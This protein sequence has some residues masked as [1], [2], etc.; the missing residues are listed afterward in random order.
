MLPCH[1]ASCAHPQDFTSVD[2][3]IDLIADPLAAAMFRIWRCRAV[4]RCKLFIV[5]GHDCF[6]PSSV[7]ET[8]CPAAMICDKHSH[9]WMNNQC[10]VKFPVHL[11]EKP[12]N[13]ITRQRH[14][15]PM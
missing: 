14:M 4:D 13:H 6:P 15:F 5:A 3:T 7:G 1:F 12:V 9:I 8:N 11:T 10:I 2:V